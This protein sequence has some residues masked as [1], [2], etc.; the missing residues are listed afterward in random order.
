[1]VRLNPKYLVLEP[2]PKPVLECHRCKAVIFEKQVYACVALTFESMGVKKYED[3]SP[4]FLALEE[5]ENEKRR[6]L[7]EPP[8]E[9]SDYV[10]DIRH[11]EQIA[12]FCMTCS[13]NMGLTKPDE[14]LEGVRRALNAIE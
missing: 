12:A 11:A 10:V 14:E 7:G 8:M 5:K 6:I 3:M 9:R 1:M 13:E 4:D 2:K